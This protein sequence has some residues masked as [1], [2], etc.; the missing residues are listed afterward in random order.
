M[1][2]LLAMG[3]ATLG[4]ALLQSKGN[5]EAAATQVAGNQA[6]IQSQENMFNQSLALN[7]PYRDAGQG[8]IQGLQSLTDPA[9]RAQMLSGYYD[10]AE[11]QG[12]QAQNE[13]QQL[14]NAAATGGVRGGANQAAMATIAPQM[15][16]QYLSGL[17]NQFTGLANMGMG[18]AS[19]GAQ[20]AQMFGQQQS[21]LQQQSA[22]AMAQNQINQSN[23]GA[24]TLGTLGGL[25]YQGFNPVIASNDLQN[26]GF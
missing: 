17:Q 21:A 12:M 26:R 5:K 14:R 10:S 9:Q 25:A 19:Q 6:A 22:Q 1:W 11:F 16:Q 8:A 18:A 3:A 24:N 23:I 4:G 7:Q 15:G 2:G 20:G 13:E